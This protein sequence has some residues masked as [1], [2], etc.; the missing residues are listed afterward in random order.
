[1]S[2]GGILTS[3]RYP[4]FYPDNVDCTWT[5]AAEDGYRVRLDFEYFDFEDGGIP[6]LYDGLEVCKCDLFQNSFFH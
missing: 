5:L 1:M 4:N 2:G 3:P 6:C